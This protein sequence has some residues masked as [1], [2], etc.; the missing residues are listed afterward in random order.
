MEDFVPCDHEAGSWPAEGFYRENSPFGLS[1]A[2]RFAEFS[3]FDNERDGPC[4]GDGVALFYNPVVVSRG[5]TDIRHRIE[6]GQGIH[7]DFQETSVGCFQRDLSL[8]GRSAEG[9]PFSGESRGQL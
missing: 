2:K 3:F 4:G 6:R 1:N 5:T 9:D 8:G 7:A